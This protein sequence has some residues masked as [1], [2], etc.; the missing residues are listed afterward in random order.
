MA[1]Q[2]GG[3]IM[4]SCHDCVEFLPVHVAVAKGMLS[5]TEAGQARNDIRG[6]NAFCRTE[7]LVNTCRK[8]DSGCLCFSQAGERLVH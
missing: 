6:Y 7:G 4:S 5:P 3:T 8:D 2:I 1:N